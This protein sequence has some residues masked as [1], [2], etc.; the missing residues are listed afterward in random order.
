MSVLTIF[1]YT[2][3]MD[4]LFTFLVSFSSV[5]FLLLIW[6]RSEGSQ[7]HRDWVPNLSSGLPAHLL[8]RSN[9]PFCSPSGFGFAFLFFLSFFLKKTCNSN[10]FKHNYILQHFESTKC[11]AQHLN[12]QLIPSE[13]KCQQAFEEALDCPR[14]LSEEQCITAATTLTWHRAQVLLRGVSPV[15]WSR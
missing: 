7:C 9:S 4:S 11:C 10:Y 2:H 1:L 8:Q 12:S 3:T 14:Q 6:L 15:E 5:R 13:A